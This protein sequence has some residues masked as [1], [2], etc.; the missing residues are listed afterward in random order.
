MRTP[1]LV[2]DEIQAH[3]QCD[4]AQT[5]QQGIELR[6]EDPLS[7]E[8]GRRMVQIQQPQQKCNG[9]STRDENAS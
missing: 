6:Q 8:G 4:G 7:R 9:S 3:A 2:F 5:V 1:F